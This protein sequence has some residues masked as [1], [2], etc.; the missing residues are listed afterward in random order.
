MLPVDSEHSA[1]FQCLKNETTESIE[2]IILTASGGPF[3]KWSINKIKKA[4]LQEAIAHPNW[5]MGTRISIDSATMFNKAL[6]IIE[7]KYLF[8][9]SIKDIEVLVH[10]ESIVHSMN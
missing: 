8:D 6:E 7:A 3:K 2:K 9:L 10:P 5:D 4:T 1:V